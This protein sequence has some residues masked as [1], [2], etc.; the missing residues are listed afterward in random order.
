M[1]NTVDIGDK[2]AMSVALHW[3]VVERNRAPTSASV[4]LSSS[5]L[6]SVISAEWPDT[7]G[8]CTSVYDV[9]NDDTQ[10]N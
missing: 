3:Q 2:Q 8:T 4:L 1:K 7:D 10:R 5:C 6:F 9:G